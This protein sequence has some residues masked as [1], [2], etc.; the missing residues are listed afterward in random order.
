MGSHYK[1]AHVLTYPF[2][3]AVGMIAGAFG[4]H[5]LKSR[6]GMTADSIHNWETA[7]HYSVRVS[8]CL[9]CFELAFICF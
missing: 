5:G 9:P 6:T 2:E 1:I 3:A 7:A 8:S 4:A